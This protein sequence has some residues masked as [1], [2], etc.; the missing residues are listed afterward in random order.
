[1]KTD[2]LSEVSTFP[3]RNEG[4]IW[5]A[6]TYSYMGISKEFNAGSVPT[7]AAGSPFTTLFAFANNNG[8]T[9]SVVAGIFD[10]VNRVAGVICFSGNHIVRSALGGSGSSV[11]IGDEIDVEPSV[12]E[13]PAANS[14][15]LLL[16]IYNAP[17]NGSPP[18][19][20]PA[21]QIGGI[22]SGTWQNGVVC[23]QVTGTCLAAGSSG[24]TLA[25]LWNATPGTFS[26]AA[27]VLGNAQ[28]LKFSGTSTAHAYL[29][30]DSSNNVRLVMG[31]GSAGIVFRE[32]TDTTS[33][34]TFGTTGALSD[35]L[36]YQTAG[37]VGLSPV[38]SA[39]ITSLWDSSGAT[40]CSSD[41][42]ILGNGQKLRLT[43]SAGTNAKLYD[44]ATDN[45]R[46]V[47]GAGSFFIRNSADNATIYTFALGGSFTGTGLVTGSSGVNGASATASATL[48]TGVGSGV[49]GTSS[50]TTV[51]VAVYGNATGGT[52]TGYGGYFTNLSTGAGF[53]IFATEIGASNTGVA[54]G[55]TNASAS[56]TAITS[57]GRVIMASLTTT[58]GAETSAL[59]RGAASEIFADTDATVCGLSLRR[60]KQDVKPLD[61]RAALIAV[62][63][64][65]PVSFE[66]TKAYSAWNRRPQ[67]GFIAEDIAAEYPALAQVNS[68][69]ELRSVKYPQVTA[70]LAAAIQELKHDNDNIHS[71]I[72]QLRNGTR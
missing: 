34:F 27:G 17:A 62:M 25:S 61:A 16:N 2:L 28:K 33:E 43:G 20:T 32:N 50:G 41:C 23:R 19:T 66:W 59:C 22:S 72:A 5:A 47:L 9:Q 6:Q 45:V 70:L 12:G 46:L 57:T 4:S 51:S 44:D 15:G 40:A 18:H 60:Y 71:E 39:S 63:Q 36:G 31:S 37:G 14:A 29:Y 10:C 53:G 67:I 3:L 42:A 48:G 54:G 69:G 68:A 7:P 64:L 58:A 38:S 56:G 65:R 24:G 55:F 1:M 8:A 35:L 13:T 49:Y 26:E 21:I 52:N 11:L 30:N